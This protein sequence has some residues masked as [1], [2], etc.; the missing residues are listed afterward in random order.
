MPALYVV[1]TPIGNLEDISLRALRLLKEVKL[2]AAEDTRSTRH[3]L[4]QYNIKTPLTSYHEQNKRAK[5]GYLLDCLAEKDVALVS[6]AGMPGLSDPGYE[7]ITAAI[8][9]GMPV[10]PIPGPSAV[11]TALAVSGL[12]TNQFVYLG[13]L[14]RRK[15]ERRRLLQSMVDKTWT[16]AAFEAPHRLIESL[17]DAL[18]ILG[19]R[20]TAVCRELTKL[21]EEVFRGKLSEAIRHFSQPR[22]EFTLVI[23]GCAL[24]EPQVSKLLEKELAALFRQ[25]LGAKE[26]VAILSRK[27]G[28]PRKKLYQAWLRIAKGE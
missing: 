22:G 3:L 20:E 28:L 8:Q 23:A 13:F 18:E 1:A 9:Q 21:Y 19:D 14:P 25:G 15:G 24:K 4:K 17:E 27:T 10:I 11:I 2:I 6:E 26:A 12:P 7:L 5:L 16:V